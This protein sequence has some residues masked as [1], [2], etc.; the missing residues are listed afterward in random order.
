[1]VKANKPTIS[2]NIGMAETLGKYALR[3]KYMANIIPVIPANAE[4]M[5]TAYVLITGN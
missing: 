5:I 2:I 1:M 3:K 4:V